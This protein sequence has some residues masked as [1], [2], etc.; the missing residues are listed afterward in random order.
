MQCFSRSGAYPQLARDVQDH[1]LE[2]STCL[3]GEMDEHG[4]R[5]EKTCRVVTALSTEMTPDAG[6]NV[7]ATNKLPLELVECTCTPIEGPD[8]HFARCM[9]THG[10]LVRGRCA[11]KS[12]CSTF[13]IEVLL[14]CCWS[15]ERSPSLYKVFQEYC[16][17]YT[18]SCTSLCTRMPPDSHLPGWRFLLQVFPHP[19]DRLFLSWRLML[20]RLPELGEQS[21]SPG[22]RFPLRA[23]QRLPRARA[24]LRFF[25]CVCERYYHCFRLCRSCHHLRDS[26]GSVRLLVSRK[27]CLSPRIRNHGVPLV[28]SLVI[29]VAK[30]AITASSLPG[31]AIMCEMVSRSAWQT[32]STTGATSM[33]VPRGSVKLIGE[34]ARFAG[35]VHVAGYLDHGVPLVTST[36]MQATGWRIVLAWIM[37]PLAIV[38]HVCWF[39]TTGSG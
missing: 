8:T 36:A 27:V 10:V 34:L 14:C 39:G 17:F 13:P 4:Q 11:T 23:R 38:H 15:L 2:E 21:S 31:A 16:I 30:V 32:T 19:R 12:S 24:S 29:Q 6:Y 35:G 7:P 20:S 3:F 1:A 9:D 18:F 37:A 28:M 26:S 5:G 22:K 33:D 25:H